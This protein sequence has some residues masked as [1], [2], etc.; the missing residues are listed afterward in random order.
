M[1]SEKENSEMEL[2][3][4]ETPVIQ[5]ET[6]GKRARELLPQQEPKPPLVRKVNIVIKLLD[7]TKFPVLSKYTNQMIQDLEKE[8]ILN[9]VIGCDV[10]GIVREYVRDKNSGQINRKKYT[11]S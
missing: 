7:S 4:T 6:P 8:N 5:I 10:T 1:L 3:L 11:N 2:A 9:D